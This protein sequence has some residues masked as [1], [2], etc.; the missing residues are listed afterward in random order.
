MSALGNAPV[1]LSVRDL[2]VWIHTRRRGVVRAVDGVDFDVGRGQTVGLVGESGSGKT[3]T[4]LS[5]MRLEPRAARIEGGQILFEGT[6]LVKAT[7]AQMRRRRGGMIGMV[8]Q[9]PMTSLDPSFTVG[10]QIAEGV[11]EHLR[12][13]GRE[14][15]ER[16]LDALRLV[17]IPSAEHRVHQYPH[18]MSGGMRQRVAS[19][20]ALACSPRLIIA[21]EPTTSLDV[22]IQAQYLALLDLLK[23]ETGIG[24]IM[25]THD[26][27]VVRR[28][29]DV[30]A[31]MYA[32]QIVER[33][34]AEVLFETPKHP[35]TAALLAC[36]PV[37]GS[38]SRLG[39][40]E[41]Q[42]PD[43][44]NYPPGCRFAPRCK[45]ARDVCRARNP[46]LL[47]RGGRDHVAR[48]WGTEPGGWIGN[49]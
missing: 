28:V 24:I 10:D 45:Y 1:L 9:D 13:K 29:C 26:L 49:E 44:S 27:V 41:G 40:I 2:K 7:E 14:L 3:M 8:M 31:V 4:G 30:V 12:L 35:Y 34:S 23:R 47:P 22:T 15:R 33:A 21:D 38:R 46:D 39:T 5:I 42:P 11:S 48:C 20:A 37:P 32:G 6:D 19:A 17:R 43:P 36:L 25:I 18:Q 16:V